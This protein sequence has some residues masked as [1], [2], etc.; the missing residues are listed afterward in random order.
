MRFIMVWRVG[1]AS[2]RI[3]GGGSCMLCG[4]PLNV[5]KLGCSFVQHQPELEAGALVAG[6]IAANFAQEFLLHLGFDAFGNC[7]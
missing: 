7:P 5:L 1:T 2:P 3:S 6:A 4:L